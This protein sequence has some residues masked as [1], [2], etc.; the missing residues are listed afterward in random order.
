MG[1]ECG[2]YGE[3]KGAFIVLA[4]S[5]GVN[6][7]LGKHRLSGEDYIKVDLQEV[8][9]RGKDWINQAQ[10]RAKRRAVVNAVMNGCFP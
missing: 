8:G 10:G 7:P 3:R 5:P 4:G 2:T 6:R 9:W 1:G